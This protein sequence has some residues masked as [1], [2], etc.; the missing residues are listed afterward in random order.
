MVDRW[1]HQIRGVNEVLAA[2]ARGERR[3]VLTSPTGGGKTTMMTDLIEAW[4]AAGLK[5]ALYTNRRLLLTQTRDVLDAAGIDFG[6]RA[7][8]FK[9]SG[10]PWPVQLC[11][12]QTEESRVFRWRMCPDCKGVNAQDCAP[13]EGKGQLPPAWQLHD[14]DRILLDEAHVN[15]G[16]V[17]RKILSHHLARGAAYVLVSATPLGLGDLADVMIQAGTQSELRAC[18]AL[19]A[20]HHYGPDEPDLKAIKKVELGEDLS[21]NQNRQVMMAHGVFGRVLDWYRQLN[22]EQRPTILFAPGVAE[23]VWFARQF[24]EAGIRAAHID[25]ADVWIDGEFHRSSNKTRKAVLEGS[26]DGSIKVICNRFVLR[27]GIDCPWLSHGIFVTVYGSVQSYLQSGGRL[28]RACEGKDHVTLQDHGG[29]WWR[30]LS[31]NIDRVW[32]LGDTCATIAGKISDTYRRPG[33][34]AEP[35]RCPR[36]AKIIHGPYC[37]VKQGGCGWERQPGQKPTRPVIQ[38]DGEPKELT[39]DVYK[40]KRITQRNDAA[41]IWRRMWFRAVSTKWNATFRQAEATFARE[42]NFGWPPRTLPLMPLDADD[43]FRL[44]RDVPPERLRPDPND[45]ALLDKCRDY[46]AKLL[47]KEQDQCTESAPSPDAASASPTTSSPAAT[48][49]TA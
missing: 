36:C 7:A 12:L 5:T 11:S 41:A 29:N 13:C 23:S 21:E 35:T 14:A 46:L 8:G 16:P 6:I 47:K 27:E 42:N 20:C 25:G 18:G 9:D 1:P 38:A 49:G 4:T 45:P 43:F 15:T 34:P 26:K 37:L 28:L 17:P 33:K 39:G 24:T 3:I 32:H 10:V 44:V 48:T 22:P 19:V 30:H 31:L 40:P 2:I